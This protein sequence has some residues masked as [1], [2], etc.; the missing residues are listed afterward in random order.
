MLI[1]NISTNQRTWE[2]KKIQNKN[3]HL[4]QVSDLL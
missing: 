4:I 3:S 1:F 2:L